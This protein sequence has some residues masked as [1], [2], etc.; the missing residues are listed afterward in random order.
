[1]GGHKAGGDSVSKGPGGTRLGGRGPS[2]QWDP[3]VVCQ[4]REVLADSAATRMVKDFEMIA[5]S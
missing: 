4:D 3:P 2:E 5:S 1:M